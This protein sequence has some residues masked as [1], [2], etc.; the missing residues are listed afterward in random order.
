MKQLRR[1]VFTIASIN[2]PQIPYPNLLPNIIFNPPSNYTI[3]RTLYAH[4]EQLPNGDL[5]ST[6][7]NYLPP[8]PPAVYF[9]IYRS[10]DHGQA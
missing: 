8:E 5:L 7:E 1:D 4:N 6:W 3:P 9:P 2:H 10:Q